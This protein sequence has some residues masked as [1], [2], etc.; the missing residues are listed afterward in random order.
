MVILPS[1]DVNDRLLRPDPQPL[2]AAAACLKLVVNERA[3]ETSAHGDSGATMTVSEAFR[4]DL[5]KNCRQ[6][7]LIW[8]ATSSFIDSSSSNL[9][10]GEEEQAPYRFR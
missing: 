1:L 10:H 7:I 9:H 3:W 2:R 8:T 4:F 5:A 6:M